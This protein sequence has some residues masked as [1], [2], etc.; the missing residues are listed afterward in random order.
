[1]EPAPPVTLAQA[2]A[3]RGRHRCR[4]WR[5]VVSQTLEALTKFL[6][7]SGQQKLQPKH[8][9]SNSAIMSYKFKQKQV[10]L[11]PKF[12]ACGLLPSMIAV[13]QRC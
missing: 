7:I 13:Q 11:F 4:F 6:S 12:V 2:R 1:M 10:W 5:L 3:V 8:R 9:G